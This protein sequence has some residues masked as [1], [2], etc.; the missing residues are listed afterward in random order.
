MVYMVKA[1]ICYFGAT[2]SGD[3]DRTRAYCLHV[4]AI[5]ASKAGDPVPLRTLSRA[6]NDQRTMHNH[7]AEVVDRVL[8]GHDIEANM[9][10]LYPLLGSGAFRPW[11]QP[12]PASTVC[13]DRAWSPAT[14]VN[15]VADDESASTDGSTSARMDS[16]AGGAAAAA[17]SSSSIPA[18]AASGS[19]AVPAKTHTVEQA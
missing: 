10:R 3:H 2:Y 15:P 16:E 9:P 5:L 1:L 8:D 18:V 17:A 12:T 14:S 11:E 13:A 7:A 4:L 6:A 19:G